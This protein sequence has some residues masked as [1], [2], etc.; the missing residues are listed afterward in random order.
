[1]TRQRAAAWT[2]AVCTVASHGCAGA[3]APSGFPGLAIDADCRKGSTEAHFGEAD[4]LTPGEH[5]TG[6]SR[7]LAN[8]GELP[9]PC[10]YRKGESYRF[11]NSGG[12]FGTTRVIGMT[13]LGQSSTAWFV[14][15]SAEPGSRAV[16]HERQLT[17]AEWDALGARLSSVRFWALPARVLLP[18]PPMY[19]DGCGCWTLEGYKDGRYHRI[20][21]FWSDVDLKK[22]AEASLDLPRVDRGPAARGS[23]FRW[24]AAGADA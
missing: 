6:D 12:S 1:M 16:R 20:D 22:L 3:P 4:D 23:P 5:A 15:I 8:I 19:L 10:V 7:F 21:R 17:N 2:L 24:H 9:L 18:Q 13:R 11:V 14:S